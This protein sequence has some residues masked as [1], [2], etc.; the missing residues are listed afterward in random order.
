MST[1]SLTVGPSEHPANE[2]VRDNRA[3]HLRP[4]VARPIVDRE[5]A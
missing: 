4:S 2:W 1:V 5:A 3:T